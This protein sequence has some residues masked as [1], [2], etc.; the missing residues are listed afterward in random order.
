MH[1]QL[2]EVVV[3]DTG[4]PTGRG[5]Y[6]G[7]DFA[8]DELVEACPVVLFNGSFGS[9]P[10]AVRKL[11]FN[12]GHLAGTSAMHCLALGYGSLYN[13]ANPANMRYEADAGLGLLRFRASRAIASGEELTINYNAVGGGSQSAEDTWF[14]RMGVAVYDADTSG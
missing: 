14:N 12:W 6:A 5:A 9:V 13:H 2:P 7:R 8:P 1:I 11:L 10:D 4:T 3:R